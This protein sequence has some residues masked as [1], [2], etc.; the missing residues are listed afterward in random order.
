MKNM[1]RKMVT[2][3][4][5][6][7]S[8][9]TNYTIMI[10]PKF[11]YLS[12]VCICSVSVIYWSSNFLM[13]CVEFQLYRSII[14]KVITAIHLLISHTYAQRVIIYVAKKYSDPMIKPITLKTSKTVPSY[15]RAP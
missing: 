4:G 10:V 14:I 7:N 11:E 9:I 1:K 12:T 15:C 6:T 2:K 13:H 5:N 3:N 8:K